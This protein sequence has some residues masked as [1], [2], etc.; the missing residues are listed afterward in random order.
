MELAKT[1]W[2]DEDKKEFLE[3]LMSFSK[4]KEKAQWE[5]KLINSELPCIAVQSPD[6]SRITKEIKKGNYISFVDLWLWDNVACT[7]IIGALITQIKDF[8]L[9]KKYIVKFAHKIDNWASCDCLKFKVN[10]DNKE[11]FY[12]LALE[13][14]KSEA[15]FAR[16]VGVRIL[17]KLIDD[18]YIDNIFN[19]LNGFFDESEYY[20]NMVNSW[21]IAECF[22][23]Y[24][25]KTLAF[26]QTHKLNKFTINKAISKCRDSFRVSQ[27]DK[28]MLLSYRQ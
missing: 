28:E 3:Y 6:I 26:L 22:A 15:T 19:I 27:E 2:R 24:R 20:V 13:L 5:Q 10:D 23:K 11:K 18:E 8:N 21:L 4:G 16:R 9:M 7:F 14:V 25:D 1:L 12:Q 17:F